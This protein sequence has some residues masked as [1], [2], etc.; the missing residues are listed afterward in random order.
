MTE[1]TKT[2]IYEHESVMVKEVLEG[3][4]LPKKRNV[5][6]A[7]LGLGGHTKAILE[8]MPKNGKVIGF[9][10]DFEHIKVAKRKLRKFKDQVVFVNSN[11]LY[12]EDEMKKTRVRAVDA[13]LYDLGLA[14]PHVD[15]D[16]RGFSFRKDGPLDMRFNRKEGIT[17]AEVLNEYS[18]KE[19]LRIFKEYGEEKRSRRI[20]QEIR[21]SR[22][23]KPFKTTKQLANFIEKLVGRSGK[24]HPATRVFQALRIEVNKELDVL[25]ESLKQAVNLVKPGGRIVVISYHSLEDRIVKYFFR[26]LARGGDVKPVLKLITKKP[27]EPT[28]DEI[29]QNPRSRSAK[30]R[31]AEKL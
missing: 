16:E 8:N 23:S 27:L 5:I 13:V 22:K 26:D 20:A 21:K 11:F 18:E 29:T 1:D 28:N 15:I 24:I 2:D 3:L 9:D 12:L 30:L 17:A 4:S 6:D 31:V 10:T 19:L 14:S 25:R 7:T